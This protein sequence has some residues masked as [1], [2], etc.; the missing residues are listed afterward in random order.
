MISPYLGGDRTA[1]GIH[2][3]LQKSMWGMPITGDLDTLDVAA[4]QVESTKG[5]YYCG[6]FDVSEE[7][8]VMKMLE[9]YH[10]L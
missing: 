9:K 1:L 3:P 10:A 2:D 8:A 6:A 7:E 4:D 5:I